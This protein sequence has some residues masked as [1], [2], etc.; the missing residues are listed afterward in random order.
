[1]GLSAMALLLDSAFEFLASNDAVVSVGVVAGDPALGAPVERR[2]HAEAQLLSHL[3]H[4]QPLFAAPL[5]TQ[6]GDKLGIGD[7]AQAH[8]VL[9]LRASE[10]VPEIG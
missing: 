8:E 9:M 3:R 5:L 7:G 4:V 1:M 6:V 2:R 10:P